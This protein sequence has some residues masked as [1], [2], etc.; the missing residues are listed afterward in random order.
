MQS[1][2]LELAQRALEA[3]GLEE[4]I[5]AWLRAEGFAIEGDGDMVRLV[6]PW[7]DS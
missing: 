1:E 7:L 5:H 3:V 2:S 4:A 6:G